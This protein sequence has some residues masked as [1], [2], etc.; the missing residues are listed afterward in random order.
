MMH[1]WKELRHYG[2]PR[3][4]GAVIHEKV[5]VFVVE[6]L[7]RPMSISLSALKR[8]S[9]IRVDYQRRCILAGCSSVPLMKEI[10]P[11]MD[12]SRVWQSMAH[13]DDR[14]KPEGVIIVPRAE[15]ADK[16]RAFVWGK[17]CDD[18]TNI[19]VDNTTN[20]NSISR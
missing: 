6:N 3:Q 13:S 14:R 16:R 9:E 7:F 20:C 5:A 12:E 11:P 17:A 18:I 15:R 10:G 2:G 4:D 1:P 8:K 19:Q